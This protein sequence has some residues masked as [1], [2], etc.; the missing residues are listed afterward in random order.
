MKKTN[1]ASLA[2]NLEKISPPAKN[3]PRGAAVII[4]GVAIINE[5]NAEKKTYGE[6]AA[7]LFASIMRDVCGCTRI[8][9]VFDVY[10]DVSIKNAE[11]SNRG[12]NASAIL[13]NTIMPGH[14]VQQW[15]SVL[16]CSASKTTLIKFLYDEWQKPEYLAK[17]QKKTMYITCEN[18]CTKLSEESAPLVPELD[19]SQEEADTRIL[20]HAKH[21]STAHEAIVVVSEDTD[22]TILAL[23]FYRDIGDI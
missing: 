21:A 20:L 7:T 9:V 4:D 16:R 2:R 8:D 5:V 12:H 1:K 23:A 19:T 11:R 15:R 18:H 6:L 3:V 10:Q 22:V 17:L 14:K 13:L